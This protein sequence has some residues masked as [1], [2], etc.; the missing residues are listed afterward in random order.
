VLQEL[1]KQVVSTL[2]AFGLDHCAQGVHPFAGFLA[3][4]V[5]RGS[6]DRFL[7]YG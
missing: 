1:F 5:G 3:I 6:A 4:G 7:G 2:G